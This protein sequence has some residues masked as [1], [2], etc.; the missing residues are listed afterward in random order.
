[1]S[2]SWTIHIL[3]LEHSYFG[4]DH[5]L[6]GVLRTGTLI[7]W[8]W[9]THILEVE[10]SCL[11]GNIYGLEKN[12]QYF[13]LTQKSWKHIS[14]ACRQISY[15]ETLAHSKA[16]DPTIYNSEASFSNAL[17]CALWTRKV[18]I[19]SRIWNPDAE[20]CWLAKVWGGISPSQFVCQISSGTK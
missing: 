17:A 12:I 19:Y 13:L 10:H 11:E 20:I 1:M 18:L 6:N 15:T 2:W 14:A 8:I 3:E 4:G 16:L 9:D 5:I 7:A